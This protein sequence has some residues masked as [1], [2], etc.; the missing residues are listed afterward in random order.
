[1]K[2]GLVQIPVEHWNCPGL[3]LNS[4]VG[5]VRQ[6]EAFARGNIFRANL[7]LPLSPLE[8][9]KGTEQPAPNPGLWCSKGAALLQEQQLAVVLHGAIP[10]A[11]IACYPTVL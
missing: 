3:H 7:N 1:M 2:A 5:R 10:H 8:F 4:A 11:G 6:G 9:S